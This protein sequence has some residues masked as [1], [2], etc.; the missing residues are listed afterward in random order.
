MFRHASLAARRGRKWFP[1]MWRWGGVGA[2]GG[3]DVEDAVV[4]EEEEGAPPL[5][6]TPQAEPPS[7]AEGGHP[8]T[9]P[10]NPFFSRESWFCAQLHEHQGVDRY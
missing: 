8:T 10:N 9:P 7:L 3:D 2:K 6:T 1:E 4:E 5:S